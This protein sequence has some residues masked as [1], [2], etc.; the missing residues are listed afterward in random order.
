MAATG[1]HGNIRIP[2]SKWWDLLSKCSLKI[3]P[4]KMMLW[5]CNPA[6]RNTRISGVAVSRFGLKVLFIPRLK[7]HIRNPDLLVSNVENQRSK[8]WMFNP[9]SGILRGGTPWW[10]DLGGNLPEMHGF[11]AQFLGFCNMFPS[12][13][14]MGRELLTTSI[15]HENSWVVLR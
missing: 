8:W 6:P 11:Y 4:L 9:S 3:N 7:N 2:T 5:T 15:Y 10:I 13:K 14:I 12:K 1:N